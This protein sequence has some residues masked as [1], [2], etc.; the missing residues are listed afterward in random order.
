M[1]PYDLGVHCGMVPQHEAVR[2]QHSPR[3]ASESLFRGDFTRALNSI[4]SHY[5]I[6]FSH[7]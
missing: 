2:V 6:T 3:H 4:H 7:L 5:L 1:E